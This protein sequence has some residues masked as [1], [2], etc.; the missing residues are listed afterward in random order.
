MGFSIREYPLTT[1][2]GIL[3]ILFYC[4]F[5][6]VSWVF[7]P[8]PYSPITNYLSRLGDLNYSP[9]GGYFY[10]IGCILTGIA[11]IPFF[12]GLIDWHTENIIQRVI[13]VIG[14]LLGV[15]S[16]FA[17]M[18]IGV[19]SEDTGEPH[20]T[21]SGVFFLL[22]FFVLIIIIIALFLNSKF[23]RLV[24]VYGLA[25]TL[26]SLG[27]ALTLRSALIEWYTV[28]GSLIFVG[29]VAW[30]SLRLRNHQ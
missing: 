16:G 24:G 15:A 17:L 7:Y 14:Q 29:L 22:N 11:L 2:S 21:A 28:F 12:L 1:I 19:F 26:S 30:N 5:T 6:L 10:N 4:V 8:G 3:V 23:N 27:F 20:I 13:M 9:F 25:I 18:A